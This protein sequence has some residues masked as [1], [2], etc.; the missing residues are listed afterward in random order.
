MDPILIIT[1]ANIIFI[2]WIHWI[3]YGSNPTLASSDNLWEN[4]T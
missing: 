3:H 4:A 2:Y 1:D